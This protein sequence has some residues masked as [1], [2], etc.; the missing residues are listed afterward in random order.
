MSL[1]AIGSRLF[2]HG[3]FVVRQ[4]VKRDYNVNISEKIN[5]GHQ[6]VVPAP[7]APSTAQLVPR[8]FALRTVG[9]Q[10]GL[11]ARR[12]FI[13]NVLN[14][15]TNTLAAELRKKAARR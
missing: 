9:I 3:R 6:A 15:V 11:H 7:Q 14:R 13:D 1:R 2:N 5:A 12:I 4:F 8:N 10:V